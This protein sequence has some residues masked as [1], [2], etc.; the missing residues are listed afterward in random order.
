[1][2][3]NLCFFYTRFLVPQRALHIFCVN[4]FAFAVLKK[5]LFAFSEANGQ[6]YERALLLFLH[7]CSVCWNLKF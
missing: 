7:R 3:V 4:D 1:M 6:I 2:P 5:R